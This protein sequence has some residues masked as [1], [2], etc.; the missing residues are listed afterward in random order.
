[1]SI[2]RLILLA[3]KVE[4]R[5]GGLQPKIRSNFNLKSAPRLVQHDHWYNICLIDLKPINGCQSA[6]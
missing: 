4:H 6:A 2:H 5:P 3:V 1:M